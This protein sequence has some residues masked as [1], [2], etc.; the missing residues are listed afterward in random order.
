MKIRSSKL[1]P[2]AVKILFLFPLKRKRL[3]RKAGGIVIE[4]IEFLL[5][6][7]KKKGQTNKSL[8]L[9]FIELLFS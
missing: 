4:N 5:Q 7:I 6:K 8:S 2:I 3:T 9:I 1:A